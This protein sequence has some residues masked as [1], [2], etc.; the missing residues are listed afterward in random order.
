M[1]LWKDDR[2]SPVCR[3]GIA[4]DFLPAAGGMSNSRQDWAET[5][6][7]VSA[8]FEDLEFSVVN[9]E[10]PVQ[11]QG[12]PARVKASLGDTFAAG[13][14]ALGYLSAL[15]A[16]VVGLANN[17]L[18]D[19]GR[20]GAQ[21][22]REV[23]LEGSF[24]PVGYGRS[25]ADPPDVVTRPCGAGRVGVW[26]AGRNLPYSATTTAAGIEPA[27]F[28]RAREA[29]DL[30]SRRGASCRVAF[31][32]AGAEGTNFPDPDD[33]R[34]MDALATAGF[35]IVAACHSHRVSGYRRALEKAGRRSHCFYGLG[36]LTS[37]V[38]YSPLEHEGILAVVA[39]DAQG[40]V[41]GVEARPVY[42]DARGRARLPA[43]EES[44]AV[45]A[46]FQRVSAAILDGSYR[47]GFYRDVSKDLMGAQWRDI[48][49]AFERAGIRGILQ[50]LR[51]LRPSHVRRLYHKSLTSIGL[52]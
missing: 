9:L 49:V 14:D 8:L 6:K 39:L 13:A 27:T 45:L 3:F 5:A 18:Y 40:A 22:T 7:Q 47:Q 30:M 29:L 34:F 26:A 24:S 2:R 42:L 31:L 51:R 15:R 48:R 46:R 32:H 44:G 37:G 36:S 4:G 11:I 10:C 21:R 1:L 20:A 41:A 16:S 33:V 43:S 17:H 52:S 23:L 12:I 38:L 25:L 28:A 50:K 19:Y 35:D